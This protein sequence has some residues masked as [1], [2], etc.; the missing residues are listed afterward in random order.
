ML[1]YKIYQNKTKGNKAYG[2]WFARATVNQT[3][4][5]DKLAEH[6]VNHNTPY[7]KGAIY[8]PENTNKSVDPSDNVEVRVLLL[9]LP[10]E[11]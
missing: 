7:S 1:H 5:L 3:I 4:D 10:R 9:L 2:K 6:M 8:A 11:S